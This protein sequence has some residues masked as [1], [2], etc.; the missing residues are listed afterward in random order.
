MKAYGIFAALT[1]AFVP[2]QDASQEFKIPEPLKLEHDEL[3]AELVEAIRLGG[4]TGDAAKNVAKVLHAHFVAEEEFA[5]PP[6]GLLRQVSE[7]KFPSDVKKI[8]EMTDKLKRELPKMLE[9]HQAV[10][11]ALEALAEAAKAENQP[12]AARFAE[13]LKLHARTE[14]EVLYPA[15]IILGEYLKT[16]L[17]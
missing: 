17:K 2:R 15:A 5:L 16:K 3:H 1:L 14:E 8:L 13:K 7:G 10:V 12:Q 6:L 4:K 9:E 11:K